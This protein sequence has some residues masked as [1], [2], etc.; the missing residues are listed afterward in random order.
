[1]AHYGRT[2]AFARELYARYCN[3]VSDSMRVM[4]SYDEYRADADEDYAY[5]DPVMLYPGCPEIE[6]DWK[7]RP[8]F[9]PLLERSFLSAYATLLLIF[10]FVSVICLV[11]AGVIGYT[12]SITVAVKSKRALMDVK[13][14]GAGQGYLNRILKEQVKKVFVL[15]TAVATILMFAYYL[16]P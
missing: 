2:Y 11:S 8:V 12:R 7:Y 14:L 16:N 13:K 4:A 15:P 10:I 1:M 3:S 9:V 6:A 5:G